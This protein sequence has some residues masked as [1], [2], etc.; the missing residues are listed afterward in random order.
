[1]VAADVYTA[2]GHVGRGGWT[3]YTGSAS[4]MYRV[5]LEHLLGFT[6][7]GDVL[8]INPSV[9]DAW[10][11]FEISYRF[12]NA[13]YDITVKNPSLVRKR[14]ARVSVDGVERTSNSIPLI[15]DGQRHVVV[16]QSAL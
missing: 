13:V 10:P 8:R 6:R 7:E 15:D 11:E 3:W 16:V 4:W 14:G 2:K 9:P 12:G 5:G 1:M